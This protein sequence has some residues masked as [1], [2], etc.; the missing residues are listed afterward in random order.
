[1]M[2][3]LSGH[4]HNLLVMRRAVLD[5]YCSWLFDVLFEL[6]RR[7]DVSTY[8]DDDCCVFSRVAECLLDVWIEHNGVSCVEF[9]IRNLGGRS[10]LAKVGVLLWR[11]MR[12]IYREIK[13][14]PQAN[15]AASGGTALLHYWLTNMRGG[16]YVFNEIASMF[17]HADVY[18]HVHYPN[19]VP[20]RATHVVRETLISKLPFG[21]L[22]PQAFLPLMPWAT[23][24]LDLSGHR[25]IISSESG[26]IKGIRKPQGAVHVCYC[27]T[28]MRYVWDLYDEYYQA[29][30]CPGRIMMRLFRNYLR[31]E[32]LKSAESVDLFIANSHFVAERIRRIYR[33]DAVVIHPPVDYDYFSA[34]APVAGGNRASY[35]FVGQLVCYKRADLAVEACRRLGRRLKVVGAGAERI[36]LQALA[37]G[38]PNIEFVGRIGKEALRDEYAHAKALLFPGV[39][40]FGIVP[41]EAQAAGTP[42]IA[43]GKGGARETVRDG[44]TGLFFNEQNVDSLCGAIE[45][46]ESRKWSAEAC[47]S[48]AGQFSKAR[49]VAEMR[50][51]LG[52]G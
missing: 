23:R 10:R 48:N 27:H 17:P 39:E 22:M 25:L 50:Q 18:T 16:E 51:A 8:P 1:V 9:P 2:G 6:E 11:K 42:V 24:A 15:G 31:R 37:A 38:D 33:R 20:V 43:F 34:P 29:A 14:G 26:P 47:R 4:R 45:E 52:N 49:F 36:R 13:D 12:G 28:P 7:I 46:F 44:E 5:R 35:L 41:V 3:R 40:D 21:R 32:D 19:A 30:S